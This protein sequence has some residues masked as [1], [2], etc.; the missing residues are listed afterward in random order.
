MQPQNP[1]ALFR[2]ICVEDDSELAQFARTTLEKAGF[3]VLVTDDGQDALEKIAQA[4]EKY[5]LILADYSMPKMNG[6][7]FRRACLERFK[8]IPFVMMSGHITKADALEALDLKISAFLSKPFSEQQLLE[9]VERDCKDRIAALKEEA[10][11]LGGFISEAQLLTEEMELLLLELESNRNNPEAINRLF[12][13]AHTIKGASGFFKPDTVHRFTHRYEDY[14]SRFKK[15]L[16]TLDSPA[17]SVLLSGLDT[18]KKL[19]TCLGNHQPAWASL[20][21]LCQIFEKKLDA[22]A[23]PPTAKA[24]DTPTAK[25]PPKTETSEIRV[26]VSLLDHFMEK[27]GEITVLRNMVN[28]TLNLI[29]SR[30]TQDPNVANLAELLEEMQK[31]NEGMQDQISDLRKVSLKQVLKPLGRALRDLCVNLKKQITLEVEGDELRVDHALAQVLGNS[32]IHLIRNAADHGIELPEQRTAAGKTPNGKII[33]R[34]SES[35]EDVVIRLVD[36]GRGI[37]ATK[38]REKAIE[39][40]LITAAQAAKMPDSEVNLLIFEAGFSTADKITDVSGR[41]VGMDMVRGSIETLGG[42]IALTSTL[43][44]GTEFTL[45]LPIP[46]S[47]LIIDSVMVKVHNK[48]LAVP[49]DNITRIVQLDE[50]TRKNIQPVGQGQYLREDDALVPIVDLAN[51]FQ[52]PCPAEATGAIILARGKKGMIGFRV[53]DVLGIEDTVVKKPGP[54]FG[55]LKP[56]KGATFLGDGS[57]GLILDVDGLLDQYAVDEAQTKKP[58]NQQ[59]ASQQS[60]STD[61]AILLVQTGD[62]CTY[63]IPTL[64]VFRLEEIPASEV[65]SVGAS[66]VIQYRDRVLPLLQLAD[67]LKGQAPAAGVK[68]EATSLPVVVIKHQEKLTGLVVQ[69]IQDFVLVPKAQ[70]LHLNTLIA[71]ERAITVIEPTQCLQTAKAA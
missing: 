30:H 34:A 60:A 62:G 27:S 50:N 53:D 14:L 43:G 54:W 64:D 38:V 3:E 13:C 20:D 6:F 16:S 39:K 42:S 70:V 15:D 23:A 45:R 51:V 29:E 68:S 35:A 58:A 28:K 26:D 10:E 25:A 11:L 36:D 59:T 47:V 4:P 12:A 40:G 32:L 18:I 8:Q 19:V 56:Y 2:A 7:E 48:S 66:P 17:I 21:E 37:N 71:N 31:I 61:Q 55:S 5:A 24:P 65:Q 44:K 33:L 9:I 49:V 57:I 46:K 67:L 1:A 63:G 22:P 69:A 41:G 52:L